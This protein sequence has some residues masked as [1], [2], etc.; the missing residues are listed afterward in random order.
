MAESES[1]NNIPPDA[2]VRVRMYRQGLGDCFLLTF[3]NADRQFV[4]VL[5]DC[6]VFPGTKEGPQK[7]RTVA[8]NVADATNNSLDLL[9]ITHEHWD[10]L[11]GFYDAR[12]VFDQMRI[13]NTW[14]A[15]TEDPGQPLAL[16]RKKK[17]RLWEPLL[18]FGSP[19]VRRTKG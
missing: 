13:K 1:P 5:I 12:D 16:E 9:V 15:W 10:H 4:H 17:R 3:F 2:L 7:I 18:R 11:S 6:G 14:V 19:D 8:K